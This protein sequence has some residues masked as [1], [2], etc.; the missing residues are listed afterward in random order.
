M[1]PGAGLGGL[2]LNGGFIKIGSS[3]VRK[4]AGFNGATLSNNFSG[5]MPQ[6][7]A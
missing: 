3:R 2:S 4:P 6:G 7:D 1:N 5:L